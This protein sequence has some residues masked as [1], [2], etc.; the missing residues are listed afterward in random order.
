MTKPATIFI[1]E[2]SSYRIHSI[3][4]RI[5]DPKW[6]EFLYQIDQF[7]GLHYCILTDRC[8]L[9]LVQYHMV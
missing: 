7:D 2:Y 3:F 4:S 1:E 5:Q 6:S 9:K 8:T